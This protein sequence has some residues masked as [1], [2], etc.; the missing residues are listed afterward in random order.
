[1]ARRAEAERWTALSRRARR[2]VVRCRGPASKGI[3][4]REERL[5]VFVPKGVRDGEVLK[6]T[7][8]GEASVTGGIPGDLYIHLH[9]AH[10]KIFRRQGDNI[11]MQLPL[12][13]SQAVLGDTMTI[14]TLDGAISL[15]IPDGTQAGDV[16]K[17]RGRGAPVPS[18]YGRGDL[19]VE[20]KIEMPRK[21]SRHT[22][23]V[24]ETL[25]EEGI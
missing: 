8:K 23:K 15:K 5:E 9:V 3:G 18:G 17:V 7:G 22:R 1:M 25:R 2:E 6:V 10:H 4:E 16:L 19:L 24:F 12:K 14:E 13:L 20:I 21:L 11:V